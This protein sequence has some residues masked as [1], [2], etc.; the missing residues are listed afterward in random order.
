[1]NLSVDSS[2]AA[3]LVM[4]LVTSG[5]VVLTIAGESIDDVI[6]I[7]KND[8]PEVLRAQ[9]SLTSSE[10]MD[11]SFGVLSRSDFTSLEIQFSIL[12]QQELPWNA[13]IEGS[14]EDIALS[15]EV[16]SGLMS[17]TRNTIVPFETVSVGVGLESVVD[18]IFL[19]FPLVRL[20][21]DPSLSSE[22][23][24]SF[25][26]LRNG[27][28]VL[29]FEGCSEFF[30]NRLG[31]AFDSLLPGGTPVRS[32]IEKLRIWR[33]EAV[34]SYTSAPVL[35]TGWK[36]IYES[37]DFGRV[38]FEDVKKNER[39]SVDFTVETPERPVGMIAQVISVYADGKLLAREVN[40]ME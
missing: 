38:V 39:L 26:L 6:V 29:Y 24:T 37:P 31:G 17:E 35:P 10:R 18:A 16:V 7:L 5:L 34:V 3:I 32:S 15:V 22:V 13:S 23:R 21:T 9:A 1:M 19:D 25:L 33:D 30:F 36:D 14:L 11:F 40:L 4:V 27:T 8:Y 12:A 20:Y 28:E 2:L